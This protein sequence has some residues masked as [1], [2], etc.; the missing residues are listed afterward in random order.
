MF[1]LALSVFVASLLGSLHC[2]GMCGPFVPLAAPRRGPS[3]PWRPLLAYHFGRL[4]A[5]LLVGALAGTVGLALERGGSLLGVQRA[6]TL[7]AGATMIALGIVGLLRRLGLRLP[8]PDPSSTIARM[9]HAATAA[10]GR[11]GP[12]RRATTIGLLTAFMPCGWLYVFAVT[13]AGTGSPEW[14]AVMMTAFWLG[15]LPALTAVGVVVQRIS[16]RVRAR[17]PWLVSGLLIAI[18]VYTIAFR[19]QVVPAAPAQVE[20]VP[21]E[22]PCH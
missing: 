12:L 15:T 22:A 18:G 5:Y 16:P 8:V 21:T 19:A 17:L 1:A 7:L 6:A 10:A 11:L 14:G 3:K 13:A 4:G 20:S 9:L 2:A